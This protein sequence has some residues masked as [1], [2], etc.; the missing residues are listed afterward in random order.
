VEILF[1][2]LFWKSTTI[3]KQRVYFYLSY[4]KDD[5]KERERSKTGRKPGPVTRPRREIWAEKEVCRCDGGK[6]KAIS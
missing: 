5:S 4:W 2:Q 1:L 6:F 3:P